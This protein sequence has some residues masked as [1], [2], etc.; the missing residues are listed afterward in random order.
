MAKRKIGRY[1]KLWFYILGLSV[2]PFIESF[3]Q[4]RA[5]KLNLANIFSNYPTVQYEQ[6]IGKRFS[7]Q[8]G[9]GVY[10]VAN[11]NYNPGGTII[12]IGGK[13]L[14]SYDEGRLAQIIGDLRYYVL[15]TSARKLNGFYL[16]PHIMANY[17]TF[18]TL[19]FGAN[20]GYQYAGK[21]GLVC[22]VG[23]GAS[24]E[25][26]RE[27]LSHQIGTFPRVIIALGYCF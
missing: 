9:V 18:E 14:K 17:P 27:T 15:K 4:A 23:G 20:I 16:G 26:D 2:C 21:K 12:I 5:I 3:A 22:N 7:W 13:P 10:T 1:L 8:V 11:R 19:S 25:Y 24:F 6:A